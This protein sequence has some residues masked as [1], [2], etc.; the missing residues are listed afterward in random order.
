MMDLIEQLVKF[1]ADDQDRPQ[2]V[3]RASEGWDQLVDDWAD[4]HSLPL[5][6]RKDTGNRGSIVKH[7]SGRVLIPTDNSPAAWSFARAILNETPSLGD[8]SRE[9]A[10]DRIPVAMVLKAEER[11]TAHYKCVLRKGMNP[12]LAGWKL[13]HVNS[14]GMRNRGPSRSLRIQSWWNISASS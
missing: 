7:S 5:L 11:V 10:E 14:I 9:F 1:W 4:N 8:I 12:N 13:A 3:S 6:I 2:P